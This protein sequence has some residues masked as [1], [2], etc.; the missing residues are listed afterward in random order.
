MT[1]R[2]VWGTVGAWL[3]VIVGLVCA[4]HGRVLA[5]IT[6][7]LIAASYSDEAGTPGGVMLA[8]GAR[9]LERD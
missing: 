1:G 4:W 2:T 7:W 9:W 6:L 3:L 8:I 5:C